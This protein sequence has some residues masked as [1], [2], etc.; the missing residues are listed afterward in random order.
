MRTTKLYKI[1]IKLLKWAINRFIRVLDDKDL[2]ITNN[3]IR[4]IE[5]S[6]AYKG[7]Q[8]FKKHTNRGKEIITI[9]KEGQLGTYRTYQMK[10]KDKRK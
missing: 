1:R 10:D 6:R 3:I 7:F 2:R 5:Y 9:V 4:D 8:E